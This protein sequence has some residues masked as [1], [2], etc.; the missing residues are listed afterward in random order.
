MLKVTK[1]RETQ[2]NQSDDLAGIIVRNDAV[3]GSI[4]PFLNNLK[5]RILRLCSTTFQFS[6]LL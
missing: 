4:P 3:V 6:S 1:M 2:W 5:A